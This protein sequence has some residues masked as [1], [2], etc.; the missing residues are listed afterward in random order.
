ME[1]GVI[2]IATLITIK[3]LGILSEVLK[4]GKKQKGEQIMEIVIAI[5]GFLIVRFATEWVVEKVNNK[6]EDTEETN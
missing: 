6:E 1:I 4:K 5:V 3:C 2:V